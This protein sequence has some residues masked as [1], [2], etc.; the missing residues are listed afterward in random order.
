MQTTAGF[1]SGPPAFN[2]QPSMNSYKATGEKISMKK[3]KIHGVRNSLAFVKYVIVVFKR[4]RQHDNS[5]YGNDIYSA[6]AVFSDKG[7]IPNNSDS[8]SLRLNLQRTTATTCIYTTCI[9]RSA[10]LHTEHIAY[11]C[12]LCDHQNK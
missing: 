12:L 4:G 10:S 5:E 3:R 11:V 6:I 8:H 2:D 9:T 1:E 7:D